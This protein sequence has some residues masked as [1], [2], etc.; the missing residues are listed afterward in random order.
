MAALCGIARR[1]RY[2]LMTDVAELT[3]GDIRRAVIDIGSNSVRLVIYEG[4]HRC[5]IMVFNEKMLCG[6]GE[7][8]Q[9]TG[10]LLPGPTASALGT[11]RRFRHILDATHPEKL[12]V[13]A[14]AAVREAPNGKGF[15]D[16]VRQIGFDPKLLSGED[17][18]LLAAYGILSGVPEIL[19]DDSGALA[20]DIGGG[21]LELSHIINSAENWVGDHISLPLGALKLSVQFLDDRSAAKKHI[22]KIIRDVRWLPAL[23]SE[24]L[25]IVGGAWRSLGKILISQSNYPLEILDRYRISRADMLKLCSVVSKQN[26]ESL[27]SMDVVQRRR[28]H[29]LPF[30][31]LVLTSL[32][33]AT[34]VAT[35]EIASTGVREGML[36]SALPRE[37]QEQDPLIMAAHHLAIRF[38]SHLRPD[39]EEISNLVL[40]LFPVTDK[41]GHRLVRAASELCNFS[42]G[43]EPDERASHAAHAIMSL[44]LRGIDHEGRVFLSTAL[45]TRHGESED[46]L[47]SWLPLQFL[48]EDRLE[49]AMQLGLALRFVASL[50]PGGGEAL[51]QSR[52][53][54][55]DG[56]LMFVLPRHLQGMWGPIPAKR[57]DRLAAALGLEKDYPLI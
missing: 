23:Q 32:L 2:L 7:R 54:V 44:P 19:D 27:A 40:P 28:A 43:L 17:E 57:F 46:R 38:G 12:D 14:T 1:A 55:T 4:P 22:D 25:Y 26:V 3:S 33:E 18:A 49:E 39:A 16:L 10:D 15:L 30:A 41:R 13:F 5:P 9:E 35:I 56:K 48:S 45:A 20:G 53:E 31:A 42:A 52:F 34:D 37:V 8:D 21:S 47:R 36:F 29:T 50:S 6:L 11:L 24:K 51:S